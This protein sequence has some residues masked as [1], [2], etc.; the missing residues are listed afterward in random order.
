[1]GKKGHG[2]TH[3]GRKIPLKD[4]NVEENLPKKLSPQKRN[5]VNQLVDKLLKV[6]S[7]IQSAPNVNKEWEIYS[8]IEKLLEKISRTEAEMKI[9]VADRSAK[10][11]EFTTW[12]KENGSLIDGVK[13]TPF[14]GYDYGLKA[15][16]NFTLGDVLITVP[17]KVMLTT[18]SI[19]E[20]LLGPLLRK[21]AML[22]HMPNVALSLL[23]LVEKFKPDSFWK[24]YIAILPT[25]YTT[26]LYF[27]TSELQ[28]LKGSPSLEPALKQ[29]RNIARQYAYFNKLFQQSSDPASDLLR[30]V[31][32]YEQY[33]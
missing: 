30:D 32:T 26:V 23:L 11:E 2:K 19:E 6:S 5:E 1:M 17:R 13:I 29:C 31:F 27:K 12:M 33:W 21:D 24:P 10:I 15:E 7:S 16:K 14:P 9:P 25:E 3:G 4:S 20:S 8:E 22:Q 18:E 28:E